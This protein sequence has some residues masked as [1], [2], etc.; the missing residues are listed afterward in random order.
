MACTMKKKK[1]DLHIFL[2]SPAKLPPAP[3]PLDYYRICQMVAEFCSIRVLLN[4]RL[5]WELDN[6]YIRIGRVCQ[7]NFCGKSA[8]EWYASLLNRD[9]PCS[10]SKCSQLSNSIIDEINV[11]WNDWTEIECY[12][13]WRQ[14]VS[15]EEKLK[16]I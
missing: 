11:Y 16:V 5:Y 6:I 3:H 8:D 9:L 1:K 4:S 14:P 7:P 12:P 2:S 13:Q 15:K 10:S